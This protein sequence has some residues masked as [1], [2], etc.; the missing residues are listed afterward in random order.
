MSCETFHCLYMYVDTVILA[1]Y[2]NVE[3]HPPKITLII[4]EIF[5]D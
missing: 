4:S 5:C 1:S 3:D 2:F